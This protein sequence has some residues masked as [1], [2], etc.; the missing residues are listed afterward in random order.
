MQA[1]VRISIVTYN[2]DKVFKALDYLIQ[3]FKED[4]D[5]VISIYDNHS[6]EDFVNRLKE[7][8]RYVNITFSIENKGF[9][10]GHNANLLNAQEEYFLIFNPDILLKKDTLDKMINGLEN[11]KEATMMVPKIISEDGSP[12]HLMRKRFTLLDLVI[13]RFPIKAVRKI[14]ASRIADYECVN[15]PE[16]QN[17]YIKIGSGCFILIKSSTFKEINGFDD[18]FFMYLE[19]YDLCLRVNEISKIVYMPK[20]SVIHFWE[21]ESG[22]NL[23]L[24][25]VHMKS[26]VKFFNKWGWRFF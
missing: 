16:N 7:Y 3:E 5:F 18:R 4:P 8:E 19:D 2:S 12:Q 22:K 23:R 14:F 13:R 20:V 1:K 17:S 26:I 21:R 25:W 6:S 10:H 24:A 11:E 9:G 15:L